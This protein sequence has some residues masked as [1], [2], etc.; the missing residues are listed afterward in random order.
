[1]KRF[2]VWAMV[3]AMLLVFTACTN[4][5]PE[6]KAST[7]A[8]Q[9]EAVASKPA[10]TSAAQSSAVQSGEKKKVAYV[11]RSLSDPFAAWL[12]S[13][14]EAK[15]KNYSDTFTLEIL[16]SQ[17]DSEKEN[18]IIE[19]CITKKYD[20]VIIQPNDGEL[21]RPYAE[22]IVNAGIYCITT[23][24]KIR[25][26]KGASSVDAEPYDQGAVLAENMVKNVPKDGKVV[27]FNALS[28]NYHTTSRTKAFQEKFL[29]QRPDV[30]LLAETTIEGPSFESQALAVFED[31]VQ[32]FGA[33]DC[34][35]SVGDVQSLA[36]VNAVK[37]N[38]VYKNMQ[39][40]GVDGLPGVLLSIKE[41]RYTGTCMQ[42][43]G[44]LAELNM[45]AANELLTGAKTQ[46]DYGIDAV[47]I[48]KSNVDQYLV[49]YVKKGLLTEKDIE[50]Y[51][52]K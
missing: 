35:Y 51:N 45:K 16:D 11:A 33:I 5:A 43:A 38:P 26:L 39:A 19:T 48:D 50:K 31:W 23:N 40:Y 41:G 20:C 17:G 42:D 32:T 13:E 15:A 29:A 46:V 7:S 52:L 14:M 24:A 22:K 3:I 28:G 10:D 9:S 2:I 30:K 4:N 34:V 25:D 27:F 49:E 18:S 37:D 8:S 44:Q 47:Y 6:T 21:Q 12:A 36:C 1:M